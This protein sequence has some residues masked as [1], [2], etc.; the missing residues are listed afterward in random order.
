LSCYL[1]SLTNLSLRLI[2]EVHR[3]LL[4]GSRGAERAPGEFRRSQNW[5]G[6][7]RPGN[8]RF[9]PPPHTEVLPA[10]GE[11]EKFLHDDPVQ[12]P[13]LVKAALAH[14]QFESIH[15]FLDGN[16]RVGR[17]LVTVLLSAKERVLSRPLLYLSLYLKEHRDEYYHHLMAIRTRGEWEA[18]L[19]F[20]VEGVISVAQSATETTQRIFRLVNED[21]QHVVSLGRAAGSAARLH[22]LATREILFTI[23]EA[24]EKLGLSEVTT[25]KAAAHLEDLRIVRETTGKARNRVYVYDGYLNLLQERT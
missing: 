10:M 7:T 12:T 18:W 13:I 23:P 22:D 17:L 3:L 20:F 16:G 11:L 25:G 19:G 1:A 21:R 4:E 24:A 2:K 9:V 5:T 8:A 14:A 15:P 6:G